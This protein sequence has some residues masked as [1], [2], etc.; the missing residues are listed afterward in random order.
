MAKFVYRLQKVYE[1]R[2]RRK[3][4]QERKVAQAMDR[5]VKIEAA[6]EAKKNE[7]RL[8]RQ[9]MFQAPTT[10]LESHDLFLQKLQEDLEQLK[11]ELILA[12]Q[13]LDYE[14]KMLIKATM[15]LEALVKH[16]E[17]TYEE[18]LEEEKA[19]EMR[20]LDEVAGQ[21]FFRKQQAEIE[22]ALLE[23]G[24]GYES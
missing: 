23:E 7:M 11:Q 2:E 18:Y 5:V 10:L 12:Q 6:I 13:Q 21:R 20:R 16:K 4:E 15:D 9:N 24:G 19:I 3:K 17:K 22:E 8:V 1:L 14:K